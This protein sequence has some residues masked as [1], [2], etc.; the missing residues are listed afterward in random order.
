MRRLE[1]NRYIVALVV[2]A[3]KQDVFPQDMACTFA[4]VCWRAD[5]KMTLLALFLGERE[6]SLFFSAAPFFIVC[7]AACAGIF[8]GGAEEERISL[9][10]ARTVE[11][12]PRGGENISPSATRV[13]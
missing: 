9:F 2:A 7:A 10:S 3:T 4:P 11:R 5:K 1:S 6:S 8:L 12:A 13:L